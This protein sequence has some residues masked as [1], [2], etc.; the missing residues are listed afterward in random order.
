MGAPIEG[1]LAAL[2]GPGRRADFDG[3]APVLIQ[4]QEAADRML[5]VVESCKVAACAATF[6]DSGPALS[7]QQL[8]VSANKLT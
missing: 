5:D 1:G 8:D 7:L 4:H 2:G 3:Y 6:N